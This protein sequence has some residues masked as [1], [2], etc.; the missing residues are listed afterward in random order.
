MTA[1]QNH[2][3]RDVIE[4]LQHPNREVR[5]QA[6]RVLGSMIREGKITRQESAE[7]NNHVHT[8]YSFSPYEPSM[9]VFKAWE[10][11]LQ[12][13]GSVDHDSISAA[14]ETRYAA[15]CIGT[16]STVGFE[17]R[18]SFRNTPLADRK[19]NS[20]DGKGVAYVVVHG[21]PDHQIQA[22]KE[23]LKPVQKARNERNRRQVEKL[24]EL[25]EGTSVGSV[26]FE[27][28]V[29]PLTHID[30]GGSMTERHILAA[31]SKRII[32]QAGKGGGVLN[33]LKDELGITPAGKAQTYLRDPQNPHYLYDLLGVL[34]MHL[35]P[36]FYIDPE[37]SETLP[38]EEVISFALSIGAIPS[39]PYLGDVTESPT[40]D[41]KAEQFEDSYLEELFDVI[42]GLGFPAVTYM[43]PR[44][45]KEQLLRVQ[46]LARS[47]GLMEISGVDI[48]SSRQIFNCPELLEEEFVHLVDAA[49]AL[50]AHEAISAADASLGL[51]AEGNPLAGQP[52]EERIQR[53]NELGRRMDKHHPE[54]ILKYSEG[55]LTNG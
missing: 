3:Y 18:T 21:V 13:V 27:Q 19:I 46:K 38:I 12:I 16:G 49:W 34:K 1:Y 47:R 7:V 39:Y 43:P 52:L 14:E 17:L 37:P 11:G 42:T 5:M 54:Q 15:S 26:D 23:F 40:G 25:L 4:S 36:R 6:A 48:N 31:L 29:V 41:K 10:A 53:Y 55:V 20:P 24:N 50:V 30:E 33:L 44:N 32:Y 8:T 2:P 51:F 28:G 35:L 45:T 9:A 22:S